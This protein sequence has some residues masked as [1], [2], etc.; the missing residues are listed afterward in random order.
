MSQPISVIEIRKSY[1]KANTSPGP[2]GITIEELKNIPV[3]ILQRIFNLILFSGK[4]PKHLL[5]SKTTL[6]PKKDQAVEPGDYRPIT[7]SSVI[8]RTLHKVIAQQM[9]KYV[10]IDARQ[11]AF[12]SIDGCSRNILDLDLILRYHRQN[13][14]PLYIASMDIAKASDMV[15]HNTISDTLRHVGIPEELTGYIRDV[16]N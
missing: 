3:E 12:I 2:D 16:Y 13:L 9:L 15:S 1:P 4:M 6:I 8:T 5:E 11:R 10:H 7:V 14:K